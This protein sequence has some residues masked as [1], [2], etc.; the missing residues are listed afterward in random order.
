LFQA[1]RWDWQPHRKL[2]TK[3]L[4]VLC[5]GSTLLL[6]EDESTSII[7]RRPCWSVTKLV[8]ITFSRYCPFSPR[9]IKPWFLNWGKMSCYTHHTFLLGFPTGWLFTT[10]K[11]HQLH[12][13]RQLGVSR[14]FFYFYVES[15]PSTFMHRLREHSC[16]SEF[17]VHS[18]KVYHWLI[19]DY[20][21]TCS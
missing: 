6:T 8:C 3:Y 4:V 5:A 19:Y 20:G 17:N 14:L 13:P 16:H 7:K 21:F 15:P 9:T 10:H 12:I 11:D 1:N 2:G 18:P